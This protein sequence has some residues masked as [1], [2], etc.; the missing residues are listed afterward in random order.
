MDAILSMPEDNIPEHLRKYKKKQTTR[1]QEAKGKRLL[2][3]KS[4][5]DEVAFA[6]WT[7]KHQDVELLQKLRQ[8][9]KDYDSD[10][11]SDESW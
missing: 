11:S 8:H 3:Y 6:G 1:R 7:Y 9:L 5:S 10:D 2:D 4:T